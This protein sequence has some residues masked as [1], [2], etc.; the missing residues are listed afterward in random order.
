MVLLISF[1]AITFLLSWIAVAPLIA[2]HALPVE[3]FQILGAL[4][5]PTL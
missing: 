4:A 2:K 5:G 1:F 3:P